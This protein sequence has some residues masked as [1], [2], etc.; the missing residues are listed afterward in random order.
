MLAVIIVLFCGATLQL[1]LS[2]A[3]FMLQV[4]NTMLNTNGEVE[5]ETVA[6]E[7]VWIAYIS[8][9]I[10]PLLACPSN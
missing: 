2:L 5:E 4:N 6:K 1:F 7:A 9:T 8:N 10:P 3:T